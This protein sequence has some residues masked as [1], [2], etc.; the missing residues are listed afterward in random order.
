MLTNW[1]TC[2]I[3]CSSIYAH[4]FVC[5][6]ILLI[7]W[8]SWMSARVW[9]YKMAPGHWHSLSHSG[10]DANELCFIGDAETLG[11]WFWRIMREVDHV[12]LMIIRL[13][14]GIFQFLVSGHWNVSES[15]QHFCSIVLWSVSV[16]EIWCV[17]GS[18]QRPAPSVCKVLY[19]FSVSVRSGLLHFQLNVT[20]R[21]VRKF[22]Q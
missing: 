17:D 13:W 22:A 19:A 18:Y 5:K 21:C 10:E 2:L 14:N 4:N 15:L 12:L 7:R 1:Y 16:A 11:I 8:W 3:G 9:C 6:F 20:A